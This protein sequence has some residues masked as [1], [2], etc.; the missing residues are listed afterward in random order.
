MRLKGRLKKAQN[1]WK[2]VTVE[3]LNP[4]LLAQLHCMC[5]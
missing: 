5:V 2:E 4:L 3:I 1:D